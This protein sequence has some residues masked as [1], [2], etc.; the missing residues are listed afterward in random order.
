MCLARESTRVV[1]V[2]ASP[3]AT[4]DL[5]RNLK[6]AG[7]DDHRVV[8]GKVEEAVHDID[9]YWQ[10]AVVDPPRPGLGAGA[11]EA[12]TAARPRVVVYVSCDPAGLARD[13]CYL[14]DLGYALEWAAPVDMFPQTFHIETVA[15]FAVADPD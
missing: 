10:V 5:R 9:E 14:A 15:K 4:R 6:K 11:V 1:A 2:E 13:A 12:V 7:I 3:T 8:R